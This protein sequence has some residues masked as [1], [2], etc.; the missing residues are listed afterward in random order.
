LL[1]DRFGSTS[2]L[3]VVLVL[4]A[5]ALGVMLGRYAWP[6]RRDTPSAPVVPVRPVAGLP[7]PRDG[8]HAADEDAR[9][10][11]E[12]AEAQL[13]QARL[14]AAELEAQL[15]ES[16][17]MLRG[18]WH[19]LQHTETELGRLHRQVKELEDRK[20]A[21]IGRLESG[22]IAALESTI[23]THREQVAELDE[24][25]RAA[26]SAAQEHVRELAVERRRSAQLQSALAEQSQHIATLASE[27]A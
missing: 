25:L 10:R 15:S 22:A 2:G 21:E 13:D 17:S 11:A 20:E 27:R 3:V 18:I 23:A 12:Y 19:R 9:V 26:E 24:K 5:V 7:A 6:R 8:L 16:Q 14:R 4:A 1:L